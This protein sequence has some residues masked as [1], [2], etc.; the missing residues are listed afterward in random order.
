MKPDE[1]SRLIASLRGSHSEVLALGVRYDKPGLQVGHVFRSETWIKTC[2][3]Y[4]PSPPHT[5]PYIVS[6][7]PTEY[8]ESGDALVEDGE[9]VA[10]LPKALGRPRSSDPVCVA[11]PLKLTRRESAWLKSNGGQT[12][13]RAWINTEMSSQERESENL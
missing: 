2:A 4:A 10:V 12:A 5:V 9:V 11:F 3:P 7:C 6:G 1:I 13:V 8:D